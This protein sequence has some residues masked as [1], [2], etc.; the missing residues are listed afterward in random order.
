M[1]YSPDLKDTQFP[2]KEFM[3]GILSTLNPDADRELVAEGMKNRRPIAQDDNRDLVEVSGE[4]KD[5]VINLFSI[6]SKFS[7]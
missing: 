5:A 4:L 1:A 6:K 2:E 7:Y 3:F